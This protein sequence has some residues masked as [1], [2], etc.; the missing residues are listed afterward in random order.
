[1]KAV[2][3]VVAVLVAFVVGI[4]GG[5]IAGSNQLGTSPSGVSGS[6]N[7]NVSGTISMKSV[8]GVPYSATFTSLN[9]SAPLSST[10]QV[11]SNGEY[12]VVLPNNHSFEVYV[13][14]LDSYQNSNGLVCSTVYVGTSGSSFS[15]DMTC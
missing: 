13:E 3:A 7:V 15:F 11:S 6:H 4:A 14:Y 10:A 5:F 8:Q 2:V 9:K 12:S 1:M